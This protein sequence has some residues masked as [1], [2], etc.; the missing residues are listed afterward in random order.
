MGSCYTFVASVFVQLSQCCFPS[1]NM[2][3]F[4]S[5]LLQKSVRKTT[6]AGHSLN[7]EV[8]RMIRSMGKDI[9]P[10]QV[11][12]IWFQGCVCHHCHCEE[13]VVC[14]V[15]R[16]VSL[17][18]LADKIRFFLHRFETQVS[19]VNG[20]RVSLSAP[21]LVSCCC[22]SPSSCCCCCCYCCCCEVYLHCHV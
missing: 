13:L 5:H 8:L 21:T 19:I 12:P 14:I 22:S 15:R 10:R 20:K 6:R 3:S 1:D 2:P 17:L 9:T 16:F 11:P 4:A 18:A 7:C